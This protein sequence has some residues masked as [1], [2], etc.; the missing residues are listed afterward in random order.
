MKTLT[1][2]IPIFGVD[3][4]G[5]VFTLQPSVTGWEQI[6]PG[7]GQFV[8]RTYFDLAGL[9]IDD[10]TLFFE[11]A[12]IQETLLPATAPAAA[13]NGCIIVDIMSNK[14]LR[15]TECLHV[16]TF[17]N[18]IGSPSATLTFDQTIYMRHRIFNTDIDNLAGGYA[19][20][21]SD[22]QTGSMSPTASDRIY[23]TRVLALGGADGSYTVYPARYLLRATAEEEPEHEY[24]M[25]LKRSYDLQQQPDR[26]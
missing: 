8:S 14:P 12:G 17:G 15:N 4:A 9:A 23:V 10:K 2:E 25:R 18:L 13:G 1:K 22:N 16:I 7:G 21:L 11:A 24:L 19:I 20:K 3:K 5:P 6:V 26:D